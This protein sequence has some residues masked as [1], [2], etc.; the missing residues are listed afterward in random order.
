MGL[1]T[2][3]IKFLLFEQK[4]GVTFEKTL[5]LGRQTLNLQRDDL[6]EVFRCFGYTLTPD[7]AKQILPGSGC[8]ADELFRYLGASVIDSMDTSDYEGA[9]IVHDLNQ[10]IDA[11]LAERYTAV[12]DGGTLEHVFNYPAAIRSSMEMTALGGHFLAISPVNNFVGHGFYQ[13]SPELFVSVF[14]KKNGF[15]LRDLIFF[16]DTKDAQWY[17]VEDPEKMGRRVTL[18]NDWPAYLVVSAKRI[19]ISP[20]FSAFPSQSD[21]KRSWEGHEPASQGKN[22]T[23]MG[24]FRRAPRS[25]LRRAH[26]T[27]SRRLIGPGV[28][29]DF[30]PFDPYK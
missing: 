12:I 5:M 24:R 7:E 26:R 29:G 19:G 14:S 20:I 15:E 28:N 17:S 23:D 22:G 30:R 27:F 25:V 6:I 21:Y 10:P 9:S 11:S 13:F 4:R 18:V 1:D 8:F 3:G 16:E 2:N